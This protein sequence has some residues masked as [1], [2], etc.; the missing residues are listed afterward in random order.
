MLSETLDCADV[1]V[2]G[3]GVIGASSA[4]FLANEGIDVAVVER[5][6]IA[7]GT[8][9]RSN[10][11]VV[12]G[13]EP[14]SDLING[15]NELYK[16]I[17]GN[18]EM[19]FQYRR[20]GSYRL[21]E[22]EA[23]WEMMSR[24][25]RKQSSRGI[26]IAM[27]S[28]EEI[29]RREPSIAS[30]IVGAVEYPS[31]ATLNPILY[32]WSLFLEARRL[33]VRLHRFCEVSAIVTDTDRQVQRVVTS[34]GD[35]VTKNVVNA[36]GCWAPR[37]SEMVGIK[38]PIIPQR[39]QIIVTE[40]TGRITEMTKINEVGA[41]RK[42]LE[43]DVSKAGK[44][45]EPSSIGFVYE[46]TLD[47]NILLGGSRGF[48]G[49]NSY[50]TPEV[51]SAIA[52]RAIRFVPELKRLN[53]I[54][55]FAGLRPFISDHLPI[56]SRSTEV[57]GFYVAAGHGGAGVGLAPLTGKLVSELIRNKETSIAIEHL[58]HTRFKRS[59]GVELH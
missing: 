19:D 13:Y 15:S 32:C 8:S 42:Q 55:T 28:A 50:T 25:S 43:T 36:A 9:S 44:G 29:C 38:L 5:A 35:I 48:T 30:D 12:T 39:G 27:I 16:L 22:T 53:C 51:I 7:S 21:L 46:H 41:L 3:A 6:D 1:V 45:T 59:E 31:D 52:K 10:G 40:G 47:G 24:I 11:G 4:Y 57:K 26:K 14:L 20:K 49:F 34:R 56:I 18:V 37:V 2:I 23:D 58:S 33:G 17:A 54:R